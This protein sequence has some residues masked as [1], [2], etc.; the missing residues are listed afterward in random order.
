MHNSCLLLFNTLI[1]VISS[2][3]TSPNDL[4]VGFRVWVLVIN[5]IQQY[6]S[7]IVEVSFIGGGKRSARWKPSTCRKSL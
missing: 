5:A 4:V 3:T 1:K 6:F 7:Y 2:E